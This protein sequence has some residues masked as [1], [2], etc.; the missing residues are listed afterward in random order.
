MSEVPTPKVM[1]D[2]PELIAANEADDTHDREVDAHL[3]SGAVNVDGIYKKAFRVDLTIEDDVDASNLADAKRTQAIDER[4]AT[5]AFSDM[6]YADAAYEDSLA[7]YVDHEIE[8]DN[9]KAQEEAAAQAELE[10][11]ADE[12]RWAQA[13]P[14]QNATDEA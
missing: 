2:M 3:Q 9:L 1:S 8:I 14:K 4:L 11:A 5:D 12:A 13:D 10:Y 7:A 6:A